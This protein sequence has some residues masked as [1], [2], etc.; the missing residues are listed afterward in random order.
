MTFDMFDSFEPF[1]LNKLFVNNLLVI[2]LK[3]IKPIIIDRAESDAYRQ[4]YNELTIYLAGTGY[5]EQF[6]NV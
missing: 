5:N 3:S 1:P 2:K 6:P 4:R